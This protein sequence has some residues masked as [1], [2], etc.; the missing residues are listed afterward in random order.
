MND[1]D[2]REM[3]K[4]W[5]HWEKNISSSGGTPK[6]CWTNDSLLTPI[7]K[8]DTVTCVRHFIMADGLRLEDLTRYEYRPNE[9]PKEFRNCI[10][11]S[12]DWIVKGRSIP[13][14]KTTIETRIYKLIE[15]GKRD[16][17]TILT[18]EEITH[19]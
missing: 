19:R 15:V 13:V 9:Y 14:S 6:T 10:Q 7:K 18:Y 5:V 16:D 17:V 8:K 1:D 2:L 3:M 11:K 12:V 4:I